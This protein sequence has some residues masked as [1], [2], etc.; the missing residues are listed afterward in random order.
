MKIQ[1]HSIHHSL[2]EFLYVTKLIF[3]DWLG[4]EP[5]H[6]PSNIGHIELGVTG[7]DNRINLPDYFF[8]NADF[9]SKKDF[10]SSFFCNDVFQISG[11]LKKKLGI[12]SIPI[13]FGKELPLENKKTSLPIDIL[14]V[15]FFLISRIEEY[16][17]DKTDEH[18]R[19][20]GKDS[21]MAK[22]NIIDLPIVDIYVEILWRELAM[23][24]PGLKRKKHTY[25]KNI[26][27]DVDNPF[28]FHSSLLN[29]I[30]RSGGDLIFRKSLQMSLNTLLGTFFKDKSYEK[31]PY[32]S[33][34][35]FIINENNKVN[36]KVQF[37][38]IPFVTDKKYDGKDKFFS[39]EVSNLIKSIKQNG[40]DVGIHPGYK[41]FNSSLDF[42]KSV[43]AFK[44]NI[45]SNQLLKGR[46]HY[47]R[48]SVGE[49]ELL[50]EDNGIS[51]DSSLGN[52]DIGGF[53]CGTSRS[54]QM[55]SLKKRKILNLIEEPLL[56]MENTYFSS[57]YLNLGVGE[58][59]LD[60]MLLIKEWCKKLDSLF[61]VLW[62]NTSLI[63]NKEKEIYLELID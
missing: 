23:N 32:A 3:K 4:F 38:F 40:H 22:L 9:N 44:K 52:A 41:S 28:L 46:Q 55:F 17:S 19:F 42:K 2:P 39:I 24:F 21:F 27:C 7:F 10:Y 48:W 58:E 8:K 35:N 30:K 25:T 57:K 47:L 31:D 5:E 61:T 60:K 50:Y 16:H 11:S 14:G 59:A 13:V 18:S 36:N 49:T 56:I 62:H 45:S 33:M 20:I 63:N 6:I 12:S 29:L 1:I 54:F 15:S 37:N 43:D 26:S 53:R 51:V 34:I